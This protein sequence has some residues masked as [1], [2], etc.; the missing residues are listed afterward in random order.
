VTVVILELERIYLL[1]GVDLVEF[2]PDADA[3]AR[4]YLVS[5]LVVLIQ[6]RQLGVA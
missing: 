6:L 3:I 4:R 2:G 1:D 5:E